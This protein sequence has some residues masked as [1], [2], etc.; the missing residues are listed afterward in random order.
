MEMNILEWVFEEPCK[1][2]RVFLVLRC[3]VRAKLR[4]DIEKMKGDLSQSNTT[5]GDK[6]HAYAEVWVYDVKVEHE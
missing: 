3:F 5:K 1:Q 4:K 2:I 6:P